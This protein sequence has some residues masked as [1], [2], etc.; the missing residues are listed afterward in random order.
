MRVLFV[1]DN[2]GWVRTVETLSKQ[3]EVEVIPVG[4]KVPNRIRDYNPH[5]LVLDV[6][7]PHLNGDV[8]AQLVREDWPELPIVFASENVDPES[9]RLP[10]MTALLPKPYSAATLA[11]LITRAATYRGHFY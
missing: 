9:L 11:D 5:V 1:V 10:D 8:V 6:K 4:H 2:G 7:L 3:F